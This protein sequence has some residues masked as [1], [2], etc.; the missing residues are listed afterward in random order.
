VPDR[1]EPVLPDEDL[2]T[3]EH[4]LHLSRTPEADRLAALSDAELIEEAAGYAISLA[5]APEEKLFGIVMLLM[6]AAGAIA[7]IIVA[8]KALEAIRG[9]AAD[10]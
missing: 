4:L 5:R 10:A 1:R 7:S 2:I 3:P 6:A 9:E 8:R